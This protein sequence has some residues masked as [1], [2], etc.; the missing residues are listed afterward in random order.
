MITAG[1]FLL[2]HETDFLKRNVLIA[3]GLNQNYWRLTEIMAQLRA[4]VV[5]QQAWSKPIIQKIFKELTDPFLAEIKRS[6]ELGMFRPIDPVLLTFALMG[7]F[8]MLLFRRSLDDTYSVDQIISFMA[9]VML[10]GLMP[11]D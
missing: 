2:R 4:E 1:T 3:E 11:R 5:S 10:F 6:I 9:D 7:M 8:D